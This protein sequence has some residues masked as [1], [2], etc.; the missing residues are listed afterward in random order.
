MGL[1]LC[2][3]CKSISWTSST[4]LETTIFFEL[5]CLY[6]LFAS[7]PELILFLFSIDVVVI[8]INDNHTLSYKTC[9]QY[10]PLA[11]METLKGCVILLGPP[12]IVSI[13]LLFSPFGINVKE[14]MLPLSYCSTFHRYHIFNQH[15]LP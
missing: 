2:S 10:P 6:I 15:V 4:L 5:S 12:T 11:L 13:P 9:Q 1:D 8:S 3:S 14:N 7:P